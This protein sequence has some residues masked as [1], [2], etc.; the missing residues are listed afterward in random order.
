[1]IA[2]TIKE[3]Y[4][5][6]LASPH[7]DAG[8][9]ARRSPA[10]PIFQPQ[11]PQ[12]MP[13]APPELNSASAKQST[14]IAELCLGEKKPGSGDRFFRFRH[15]E[16]SI[17]GKSGLQNG[18]IREGT[19]AK[20]RPRNGGQRKTA[21]SPNGP[22]AIASLSVCLTRGP[23]SAH[24]GHENARFLPPKCPES[25]VFCLPEGTERNHKQGTKGIHT[26]RYTSDYLHITIVSEK[27][28]DL[29]FHGFHGFHKCVFLCAYY[30]YIIVRVIEF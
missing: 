28:K 6:R 14:R 10:K 11:K 8:K 2:K 24:F 12:K 13:P 7:K 15:P 16:M 23:Q 22:N 5:A 19:S 30:I 26:N 25:T 4:H 27:E 3:D 9:N 18:K 1:M 17:Q 29:R 20:K 21:L